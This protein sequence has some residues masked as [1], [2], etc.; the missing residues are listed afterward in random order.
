MIRSPLLWSAF[1]ACVVGA[2]APSSSQA[3]LEVLLRGVNPS[4][5]QA[6]QCGRYRFEAMEPSGTRRVEFEV[7]VESV[8]DGEDGA[9]VL[10]LWSG[11]S[12]DARVEVQ[13]EMFRGS[14]GSLLDHVIA[15][16]QTENGEKRRLTPEDWRDLPALSPA[17]V[18]PVVRDSSLAPLR[19][20]ATELVCPGRLL[21]EARTRE[22]PMGTSQVIQSE[23]RLLRVW[24]AP[25][26]PIFGVVRAT[27]TVRSERRFSQPIPGVPQ[28]GPRESHYS[29]ELLEFHRAER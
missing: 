18:L 26:A 28:R 19:H 4:Q 15:V 24:S 16:E 27:A 2:F 8:G 13:R 23:S 21:E 14:G 9:V 7:C 12:L 10:H 25:E 17:P 3:Q 1:L 6:G 20:Q 5:P 22:H 11:D 29:L